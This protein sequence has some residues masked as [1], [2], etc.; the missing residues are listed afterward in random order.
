MGKGKFCGGVAPSYCVP[1]LEI[2]DD[3]A[4]SFASE[5]LRIT[6]EGNRIIVVYDP[7]DESWRWDLLMLGRSESKARGQCRP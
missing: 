6:V 1:E 5:D 2:C 3:C 7:F 4:L